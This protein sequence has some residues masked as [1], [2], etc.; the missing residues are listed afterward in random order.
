MKVKGP[1][2]TLRD[3]EKSDIANK[4]KWFND[5][6]VNKTLLMDGP[7]DLQK[8]FEWFD[9][10]R[11]DRSRSDFVIETNDGLPLG[12]ISLVH[13][14]EI[15]KTA[16]IYIVIGQKEYWGKG[17]MLEAERLIIEWAFNSLKL[18]KIR[19]DAVANNIASIITMKK[20]G[21]Q[22]EG[23]LR[24]ERYQ[25]G[26]RIDVLRLGLLKEDFKK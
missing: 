7:L 22:I 2:I 20:L 14:S 9:K 26:R 1:N 15:H 17:I 19:A 21:F 12:N 16:E 5:P 18:E 11:S 6:V 25:N 8:S 23:T 24:K 10:S 3:M 13:I 4:V